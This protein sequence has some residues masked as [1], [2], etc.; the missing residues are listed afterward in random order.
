MHTNYVSF[1]LKKQH[2]FTE[3]VEALPILHLPPGG[4]PKQESLKWLKKFNK[5][6]TSRSFGAL[7]G[8]VTNQCSLAKCYVAIRNIIWD[9]N[10]LTMT[11]GGG[12]VTESDLESEWQE[13][14]F[15][16]MSSMQHHANLVHYK[17]TLQFT[18]LRLTSNMKNAKS[19]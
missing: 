14:S 7:A 5:N 4:Y 19:H 11:A 16:K 13:N 2:R 10:S 15:K 8:F 6:N 9:K 1:N 3:I 12:I 17:I 18:S